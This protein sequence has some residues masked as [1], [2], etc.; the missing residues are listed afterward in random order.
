MDTYSTHIRT[1]THTSPRYTHRHTHHIRHTYHTHHVLHTQ[2]SSL[3]R[4]T[5]HRHYTITH[6][7]HRHTSYTHPHED[8][9]ICSRMVNVSPPPSSSWPQGKQPRLCLCWSRPWWAGWWLWVNS[10]SSLGSFLVPS[11]RLRQSRLPHSHH[12]NG[13]LLPSS[14]VPGASSSECRPRPA[15]SRAAGSGSA[16]LGCFKAL[17]FE[18]GI[19]SGLG[20][21]GSSICPDLIPLLPIQFQELLMVAALSERD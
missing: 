15:P 17:N 9:P 1:Y 10:C 19:N 14:A 16:S 11:H 18:P 6:H 5:H 20:A 13:S 2:T 4:H 7:I 12:G 8:L 21:R 3:H